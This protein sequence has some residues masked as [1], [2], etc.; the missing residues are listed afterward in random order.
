MPKD[1]EVVV[2]LAEYRA[3]RAGII[4]PKLVLADVGDRIDNVT[5]IVVTTLNRDGSTETFASTT[6]QVTAV[7]ML[8]SAKFDVM[9]AGADE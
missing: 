5:S 6:P 7:G 4:T 2:D 9:F 8:E 1:N 3:A